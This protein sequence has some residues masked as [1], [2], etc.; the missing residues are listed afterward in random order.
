MSD[1]AASPTGRCNTFQR[2]D[3]AMLPREKHQLG[4]TQAERSQ[5]DV[6]ACLA[7]AAD[8]S[9]SFQ[10]KVGASIAL[11]RS[12]EPAALSG[13]IGAKSLDVRLRKVISI[14]RC[15]TI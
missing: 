9:F 11:R 7:L 2:V 10:C 15:N 8:S 12:I 13:E 6:P 5:G 4:C 1:K 14:G 3:S